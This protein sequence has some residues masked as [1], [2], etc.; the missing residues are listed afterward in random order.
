L[1]FARVLAIVDE[2][3]NKY[4]EITHEALLR[5]WGLAKM[6]LEEDREFL[7]WRRR[8][9]DERRTWYAA[10]DDEKIGALLSGVRLTQAA[11]WLERK[12]DVLEEEDVLFIRVSAAVESVQ[13]R[14]RS[15]E[16]TFT[17]LSAAIA[18]VCILFSIF[19]WYLCIH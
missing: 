3:G 17:R 9:T 16:R 8:F 18:G 14:S 7:S 1:A 11:Y 2:A 5:H 19:V 4:V 12:R 6:W 10:A 13:T 15:R